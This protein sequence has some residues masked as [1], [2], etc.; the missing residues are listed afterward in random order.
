LGAGAGEGFDG[1]VGG[2]SGDGEEEEGD[3]GAHATGFF[4]QD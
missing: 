2:L 3:E 4:G 1:P